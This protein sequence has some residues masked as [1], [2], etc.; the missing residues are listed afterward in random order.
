M[1][2]RLHVAYNP[3]VNNSVNIDTMKKKSFLRKQFRVLSYIVGVS[4]FAT[5]KTK[6]VAVHEVRVI[7]RFTA[8]FERWATMYVFVVLT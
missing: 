5:R 8:T 2:E 7:V 3:L 4:G 6:Y 1:L